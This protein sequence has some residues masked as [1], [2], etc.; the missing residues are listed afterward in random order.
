[1]GRGGAAVA[2]PGR[3]AAGQL[4]ARQQ[5]AEGARHVSHLSRYTDDR[6]PRPEAL[7]A[8]ARCRARGAHARGCGAAPRPALPLRTPIGEG[9]TVD[10]KDPDRYIVAVTQSG[11]G[12][13]ERDYY[14]KDDP[15]LKDIRAKYE[16]HI[17]RMLTLCGEKNAAAQ[18]KSI[19]ELE[20]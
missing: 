2:R 19:V 11:L 18:A 3:S 12:L 16:A 6:E 17:E 4:G 14:L 13:P 15:A 9:I 20:T 5:R 8:D 7:A 1:R 10:Q